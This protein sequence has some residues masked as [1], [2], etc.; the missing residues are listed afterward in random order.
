MSL[1]WE[2]LVSQGRAKNIGIAW[3]EEELEFLLLLCK[4]KNLSKN[5][6]A[7]YLREG[8]TS[9]EDYDEVTIK[10]KKPKTREELE[11]EAKKAGVDFAPEAPDSVLKEEI[12]KKEPKKKSETSQRKKK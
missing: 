8:I 6:A 12:K 10:G 3:T 7:S 5:V 2:N 1:N 9:L 11:S 4:E